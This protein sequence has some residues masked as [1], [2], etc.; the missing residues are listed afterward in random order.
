[1]AL[2]KSLIGSGYKACRTYAWSKDASSVSSGIQLFRNLRELQKRI[3]SV[4]AASGRAMYLREI[5]ELLKVDKR[6]VHD[7]LK[8]LVKRGLVEGFG[9]GR[10]RVRPDLRHAVKSYLS[11]LATKRGRSSAAQH[12]SKDAHGTGVPRGCAGSGCGVG[13]VCLRLDN[14]RGWAGSRFYAGDRYGD[15]DPSFLGYLDRV[16]YFEVSLKFSGPRNEVFVAIYFSRR[17]G[18]VKVEF[19]P[20]SNDTDV[21]RGDWRRVL[22]RGVLDLLRWALRALKAAVK[23]LGI[24]ILSKAIRVLLEEMPLLRRVLCTSVFM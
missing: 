24:E 16:S 6:R 22:E 4:L 9:D 17:E 3:L 2:S 7:S 14:V 1:M 11:S 12:R 13:S 21:R 15:R 18:V 20:Y 19:R 5:A 8:R 23:E 10:Y